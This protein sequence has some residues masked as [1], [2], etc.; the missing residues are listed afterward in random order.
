MREEARSKFF[1]DIPF[2]NTVPEDLVFDDDPLEPLLYGSNAVAATPAN[3]V[4]LWQTDHGTRVP[5]DA[6]AAV[7][8]NHPELLGRM[9]DLNKTEWHLWQALE[10]AQIAEQCPQV[11][12]FFV[13]LAGIRRTE[14]RLSVAVQFQQQAVDIQKEIGGANHEKTLRTTAGLIALMEIAGQR[15]AVE[16]IRRGREVDRLFE[17]RDV[18][19]LLSLRSLARDL[20]EKACLNEAA[21]IYRRLIKEQ[22]EPPGSRSHLARVLLAMPDR[23]NRE[24]A[25][26]VLGQAWEL[27]DSAP[28]YVRPRIL[29]WIILLNFLDGRD[30]AVAIGKLKNILRADN[31]DAFHRYIVFPVLERW[32]A[33]LS[34]ETHQFL[35]VLGSIL[36]SSSN[37]PAIQAFRD[38]RDQAP[39][40][41]DADAVNF[42]FQGDVKA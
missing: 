27:R 15:E 25:K 32:K 26:I 7:L 16:T 13:L 21:D 8:N 17:K 12:E 14:G 31:S 2:C 10:S 6:V 24:E 5:F 29:Y 33:S 3:L 4:A 9:A 18:G 36:G 35:T 34:E 19:S 42:P 22:F 28:E 20:Y 11:A 40:S 39:V 23:D 1:S 37:L 38:W 30:N 41:L